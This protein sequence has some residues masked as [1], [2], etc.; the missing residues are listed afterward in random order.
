MRQTLYVKL[1]PIKV[2]CIPIMWADGYRH[3]AKDEINM[4]TVDKWEEEIW[5]AADPRYSEIKPTV[6]RSK[7]IFFW[8]QNVRYNTHRAIVKAADGAETL[9]S[10]GGRQN[11]RRTGSAS[12]LPLEQRHCNSD[13]GRMETKDGAR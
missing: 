13:R 12:R 1:K 7:L 9:G 10:L 2:F 5:G 8:G 6:P 4:I 11:T 3:L